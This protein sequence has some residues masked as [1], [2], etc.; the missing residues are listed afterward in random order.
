MWKPWP[1]CVAAAAVAVWPTDGGEG[2]ANEEYRSP[3]SVTFTVPMAELLQGIADGERG[4]PHRESSIPFEH[5][6]SRRVRRNYGAWG[7]PSRHYLSPGEAVLGKS[8]EWK[9]E[10]VIAV[11]LHFRG[12]KY[13]H[14]HIPDWDPPAGWPW[15]HCCAGHNSKG[16]DCSNF[17][18][19][20]YNQ[21]FGLKPTG[22]VGAQSTLHEFP[23][24]GPGHHHRVRHIELPD[25]YAETVKKLRTGDL[26]YVRNHTGHIAHV[27]LWVG[28]IGQAPDKTPLVL[29]ST[30]GTVIDSNGNH[31]PCGIHLRPFREDS[32]YYHSASHAI[33]VWHEE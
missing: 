25:S 11:G 13:Q 23:G 15:K 24:P 2:C 27:V 5:W 30:G 8:I 7:P 26:L 16:V 17:S 10:R 12:Y 19:F 3:Y 20:V 21:A 22:A 31:I 14:H 9:R 32:W 1:L 33:R 29:D 4:D 18:A 6:D 28:L